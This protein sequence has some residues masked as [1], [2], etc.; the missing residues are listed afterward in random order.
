MNEDEDSQLVQRAFLCRIND[1][2]TLTGVSNQ[3]GHIEWEWSRVC[4]AL[5]LGAEK[6][7]LMLKRGEDEFREEFMKAQ[8][9]FNE[10]HYRGRSEHRSQIGQHSMES[11]AFLLMLCLFCLRRQTKVE[12][13]NMALQIVKTLL[14]RAMAGHTYSFEFVLPIA[15]PMGSEFHCKTIEFVNGTTCSLAAWSEMRKAAASKWRGLGTKAWCS[16]KITTTLQQASAFDV[17]LWLLH[18]KSTSTTSP[19]W[20]DIGHLLWPKALYTLGSAIEN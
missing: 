15:G 7:G 5:K 2:I 20:D 14:E 18:M 1:D 6:D 9:S 19:S 16:H 4:S 11:R 17:L 3:Q 13:K 8:C 12:S 10:F